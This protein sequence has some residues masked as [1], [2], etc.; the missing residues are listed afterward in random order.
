MFNENIDDNV[1]VPSLGVLKL[2]FLL[3]DMY[4]NYTLTP[5]EMQNLMN[6]Y[7]DKYTHIDKVIMLIYGITSV[8]SYILNE[9]KIDK[10]R[11]NN[12]DLTDKEK[13]TENN[14]LITPQIVLDTN[15][16][17]LVIGYDYAYIKKPT[18][19]PN[20]ELSEIE[21]IIATDEHINYDINYPFIFIDNHDE[22]LYIIPPI[23]YNKF[24]NDFIN[25]D[26]LVQYD[27][28]F[29]VNV[30][31]LDMQHIYSAQPFDQNKGETIEVDSES[32]K[33]NNYNYDTSFKITDNKNNFVYLVRQHK[34]T[35][36]N[37]TDNEYKLYQIIVDDHYNIYNIYW[38]NDHYIC[39]K[40]YLKQAELNT[41]Q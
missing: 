34:S 31:S 35:Q 29:I 14:E 37:A 1:N 20:V 41:A 3:Q 9:E 24:I 2:S 17:D 28:M 27:N 26:S 33:L 11:V 32:L 6:H 22:N 5:I 23:E 19:T 21:K 16:G 7:G 8:K 38:N 39:E 15:I 18:Y 25:P 36:P 40:L 30:S 12:E 4:D 13:Q 10:Q